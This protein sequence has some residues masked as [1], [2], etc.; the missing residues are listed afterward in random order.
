[1]ANTLSTEAP[2]DFGVNFE[3]SVENLRNPYKPGAFV[4]ADGAN[5]S[6]DHFMTKSLQAT[7]YEAYSRQQTSYPQKRQQ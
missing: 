2:T 3:G 5:P 4:K 1:M 7:V 6:F